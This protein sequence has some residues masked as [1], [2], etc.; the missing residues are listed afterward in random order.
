MKTIVLVVCL[1]VGAL[2]TIAPLLLS[3]EQVSAQ[4]MNPNM[5]RNFTMAN[6]SWMMNPNMMGPMMMNPNMM[7]PMTSSQNITGSIKLMP[8]MFNFVAS[9]IKVN[10]SDAVA[11]AQNQ[12]GEKSRIVSANLGIENGY[13]TYTVCAIDT[14]MNIH[15][16]IIDPGN[17]KVLFT[18][19]LPWHNMMNPWIMSHMWR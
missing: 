16:L 1:T 10:L 2:A 8:T 6:G 14:D 19:K 9:Q 11:S 4:M 17:G 3:S 15:R 18:Q 13:L 7:G 5:M 12:L